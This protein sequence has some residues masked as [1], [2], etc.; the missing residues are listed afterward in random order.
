MEKNTH[1][2]YVWCVC[3]DQSNEGIKEELNL[4]SCQSPGNYT[5]IHNTDSSWVWLPALIQLKSSEQ[6]ITVW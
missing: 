1:T 3:G 5:T 4:W 6:L 2:F